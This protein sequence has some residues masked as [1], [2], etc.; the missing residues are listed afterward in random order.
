MGV[1]MMY[2]TTMPLYT[3]PL[4]V[5]AK[6]CGVCCR[7]PIPNVGDDDWVMPNQL[8]LSIMNVV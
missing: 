1:N 3:M 7:L 5:L 8:M 2:L 6:M 4:D